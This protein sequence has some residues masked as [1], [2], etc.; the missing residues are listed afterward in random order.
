MLFKEAKEILNNAG[1]YLTEAENGKINVIAN[2]HIKHDTV[3]RADMTTKEGRRTFHMLHKAFG[4]NEAAEGVQKVGGS[5]VGMFHKS[6]D[7]VDSAWTWVDVDGIQEE[8]N[9]FNITVNEQH[10]QAS[11]TKSAEDEATADW[12]HNGA[13]GENSNSVWYFITTTDRTWQLK[14]TGD[15]EGFNE[16]MESW[17]AGYGNASAE[18]VAEYFNN[19]GAAELE[20]LVKKFIPSYEKDK[21]NYE[22]EVDVKVA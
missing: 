21:S 9:G 10:T 3:K 4:V 16:L 19:D 12:G 1:Y 14:L 18:D 7:R 11:V 22:I 13:Y 20:A 8:L 17:D 15:V 6:G 5:T 2:I